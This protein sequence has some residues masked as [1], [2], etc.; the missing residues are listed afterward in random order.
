[1]ALTQVTS[2]LISS[3][4]N[5]AITGNIIS[6]QITSV[7][8]TQVTGLMTASQIASVANT[9]VT[10]LITSGQI[11]TVANTQVTGVLNSSQLA[12]T[13]V[14]AG[15][16]GGAT[17]IPVICV[18]NQGQLTSV[19]NSSI[20][21]GTI[22]TQN[23]S[24]VCITGG[25]V[26]VNYVCSNT[27]MIAPTLCASS[28]IISPINCGTTCMVAPIICASGGNFNTNCCVTSSGMICSAACVQSPTICA[29]GGNFTTNCCLSSACVASSYVNGTTCVISPIVCASTCFVGNGSG[30]TNLPSSS[31]L[32]L[33]CSLGSAMTCCSPAAVCGIPCCNRWLVV[34]E[35]CCTGGGPLM[36]QL[37]N[38]GNYCGTWY[39]TS[40]KINTSATCYCCCGNQGSYT[41]AY[42]EPFSCGGNRKTGS[43]LIHGINGL[44]T[45]GYPSFEAT[46][47]T[48]DTSNFGVAYAS[49]YIPT[50]ACTFDSI[51][52]TYFGNNV[53][54]WCISVYGFAS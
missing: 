42:L 37:G 13:G 35:L 10:G 25:N 52:L 49:G 1:M 21:L 15:I 5:T 11:A 28:C 39:N 30:L 2:G 27:C 23:Y 26:C 6:S 34:F 14:S 47:S 51:K 32:T 18:N 24:N 31:G 8:N 40:L 45:C 12:N 54:G 33:L 22:A 50:T 41:C 3:V 38:A 4:A 20:T 53:Y 9:Q 48:L 19:S 7:A 29:S 36:F 46:T 17:Q 16:Y 43:I 44:T